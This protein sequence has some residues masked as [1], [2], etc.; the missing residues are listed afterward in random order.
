MKLILNAGALQI[1]LSRLS[2]CHKLGINNFKVNDE[3]L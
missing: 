2:E 1:T 3:I